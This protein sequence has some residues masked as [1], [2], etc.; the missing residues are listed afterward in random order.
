MPIRSYS[1][2][3]KSHFFLHFFKKDISFDIPLKFLKFHI[4]VDECYSEGKVSH[5]FFQCPTFN[6]RQYRKK[7]FKKRSKGIRFF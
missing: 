2:L 4:N 5:I 6:F 3:K 7:S 1:K